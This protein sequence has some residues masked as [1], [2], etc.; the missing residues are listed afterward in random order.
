MTPFRIKDRMVSELKTK[1]EPE[2]TMI[3]VGDTV[4]RTAELNANYPDIGDVIEKAGGRCRV[5]WR[6][7]MVPNFYRPEEMNVRPGKRTW[8]AESRLTK[9]N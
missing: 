9:I 1:P 2:R 5:A 8:V 3:N 7:K 6:D 4:K